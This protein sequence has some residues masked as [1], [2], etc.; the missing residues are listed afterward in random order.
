MPPRCPRGRTSRRI[1]RRAAIHS[2]ITSQKTQHEHA[3]DVE[4]VREERAVARVGALLRLHPADGEDHV[5]GLAG[6]QIAAARTSVPQQAPAAR[7]PALDLGAVGRRRAGVSPPR[8]LLDPAERGDVVVRAEQDPGLARAGLRREVGLPLDEA[9]RP[10]LAPSSPSPGAFP[11]RIARRRTG[12]ASPSISR[13]RIP[14]TSVRTW[15]PDRARSAGSTR[16]V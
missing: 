14:G 16:I 6:E 1:A 10:L 2:R 3:G 9:M 4:A 11:S 15:S 7:V 5:I 8:L 13:K 12:S